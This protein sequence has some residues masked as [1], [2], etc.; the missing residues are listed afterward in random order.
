MRAVIEG[1]YEKNISFA[2]AFVIP[3]SLS[4]VRVRAP[5]PTPN[6]TFAGDLFTHTG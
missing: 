5:A 2:P 6:D 1:Y 4:F 3:C